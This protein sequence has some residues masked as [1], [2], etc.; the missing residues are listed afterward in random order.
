[1]EMSSQLDSAAVF[2]LGRSTPGTHWTGGLYISYI[3][4]K[5]K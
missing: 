4:H 5:L 1:M 2:T 3:A